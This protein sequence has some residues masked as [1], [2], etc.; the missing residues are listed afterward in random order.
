MNPYIFFYGEGWTAGDS[1]LPGV[2]WA[3]K[4]NVGKMTDIAV[5]SDDIRDAV[6]GHYSN[7]EDR[8]FA[9]GKPGNEETVKI[10]IVAA[11][12][13]PQVDYSKGNN[14]KFPYASSPEMIVNYV[15]CHDDL[16]LTDKLRKSMPDA[17]D[18]ERMAAAKLAQTIVFTSQ[19]TPFMF[20]GE[21]IFRDKQ[22]VHNS[23]KSPDSIN[24]IDWTLKTKNRDQMDYYKGLIALRKE[25]PA[26]RMTSAEQIAKHLEF[27]K[28]DSEKTPNLISYTLKDNANGDS[29]KD[30]KVI[31]NGSDEA[32]TVKLPKGTWQAAVKDGK[33]D[34]RAG[35]GTFK[36]SVTVA[37]RT[38]LILKR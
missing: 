16:T 14:S 32:R 4:E 18:E 30:I 27:D 12:A 22:G 7:A 3:L 34:T 36:G 21:E 15:S 8:G 26:F 24:A 28:I 31:F 29:W 23:Y 37:P 33:I 20:A 6:K 38:A 35:L 5:F 2:Q 13:H 25:H 17:T 11:T 9:T 19:G 1:P 10:G